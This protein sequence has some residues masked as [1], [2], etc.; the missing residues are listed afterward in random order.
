[1]LV[2]KIVEKKRKEKEETR[3]FVEFYFTQGMLTMP[4]MEGNPIILHE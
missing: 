2:E 1:M 4:G 3:E